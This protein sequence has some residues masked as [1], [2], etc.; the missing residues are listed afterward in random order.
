MK[1]INAL[2]LPKLFA[3]GEQIMRRG[4]KLMY[5]AF[6]ARW[7]PGAVR[8]AAFEDE[9]EFLAVHAVDAWD[10]NGN[11]LEL[12]IPAD[13]VSEDDPEDFD[14]DSAYDALVNSGEL[15]VLFM[16]QF[17]LTESGVVDFSTIE[18][19]VMPDDDPDGLDTYGRN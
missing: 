8:C 3:L 4:E 9:E 7:Y 18:D 10:V 11:M 14:D 1:E 16:P 13:L 2:P 5:K 19:V 17:Q 15:L 12:V 6:C